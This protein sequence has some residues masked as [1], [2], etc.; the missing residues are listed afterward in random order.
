MKKLPPGPQGQTRGF[1][2]VS[3]GAKLHPRKGHAKPSDVPRPFLLINKQMVYRHYIFVCIIKSTWG[4]TGGSISLGYMKP[5]Q[6]TE[7]GEERRGEIKKERKGKGRKG[8][9]RAPDE[10]QVNH[11][12]VCHRCH[13]AGL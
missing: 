3:K 6:E 8:E 1:C 9:G 11:L 13:M 12:M 7:L 4:W 10:V 5:C 2:F